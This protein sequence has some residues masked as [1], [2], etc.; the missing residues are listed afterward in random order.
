[1]PSFDMYC[2]LYLEMYLLSF[3]CTWS[4]LY[5]SKKWYNDSCSCLLPPPSTRSFLRLGD[6][7]QIIKM[8]GSFS[9]AFLTLGLFELDL[10]RV[11][12]YILCGFTIPL[13]LAIV[14]KGSLEWTFWTDIL[15]VICSLSQVWGL[16]RVFCFQSSFSIFPYS[17]MSYYLTDNFHIL[18]FVVVVVFLFHQRSFFLLVFFV[19]FRGFLREGG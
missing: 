3:S 6:L 1:M 18:W 4:P 2:V 13:N 5:Q 17:K 14:I 19:V 9:S 7:L 10:C 16:R 12:N 11:M 15:L 8:M